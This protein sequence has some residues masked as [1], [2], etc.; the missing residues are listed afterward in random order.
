MIRARL[1]ESYFNTIGEDDTD[2]TN[3]LVKTLSLTDQ[4]IEQEWNNNP[5]LRQRIS[6]EEELNLQMAEEEVSSEDDENDDMSISSQ[7]E[8]DTESDPEDL[9]DVIRMARNN[10]KQENTSSWRQPAYKSDINPTRTPE[11]PGDYLRNLRNPKMLDID[12]VSKIADKR[13]IVDEWFAEMELIVKSNLDKY[14]TTESILLLFQHSSTGAAKQLI[15]GTVWDLNADP[16]LFVAEFR[17]VAYLLLVGVDYLTD[18]AR[19][20]EEEKEE[21]RERLSKL[22]VCHLCDVEKFNCDYQKELMRLPLS[23]HKP[24]VEA[25]IRKLPVISQTLLKDWQTKSNEVQFSL[26]YAQAMVETYLG[27]RCDELKLQKQIETWSS[28]CCSKYSSG[29]TTSCPMRFRKTNNRYP[30]KK[31]RKTKK[32]VMKRRGKKTPFKP[33]KFFTKGKKPPCP[34][35]KPASKCKCWIC[36]EEGHY[37]NAC[38]QREKLPQRVNLVEE[39]QTIGFEPLEDEDYDGEAFYLTIEEVLETDDEQ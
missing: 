1:E 29:H 19:K 16:E 27:K 3:L 18:Q 12:C 13:R 25:Y 38:P 35:G 11:R 30:K 17:K 36:K 4:E 24:W 31:Y 23:E 37:A 20:I 7:E 15:T 34:K 9:E 33:G 6:P 5:E 21:A 22:Q 32:R 39:Y 14:Q 2:L 10:V 28:L 26:A 8:P